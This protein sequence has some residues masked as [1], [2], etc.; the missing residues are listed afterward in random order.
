MKC[1]HLRWQTLVKNKSWKCRGCGTVRTAH[2]EV[3]SL[4]SIRDLMPKS[5]DRR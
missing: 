4:E 1:K 5:K 2:G 3:N